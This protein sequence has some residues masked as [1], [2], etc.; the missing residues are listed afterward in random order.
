MIPNTKLYQDYKNNLEKELQQL[1]QFEKCIK[2]NDLSAARLAAIN[3]GIIHR[4]TIVLS[5][6]IE[7]TVWD[8][9]SEVHDLNNG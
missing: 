8:I 5:H 6:E 2:E 7:N 1:G 9:F 3:Y 4:T